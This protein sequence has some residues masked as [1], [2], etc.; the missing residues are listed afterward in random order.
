MTSIVCWFNKE[1]SESIWIVGDSRISK[2]SGKENTVLIDSGAKLF[3]IPVICRKPSETGFFDNLFYVNTLGMAYAGSSLVGLN[4]QAALSTILTNLCSVGAIPSLSEIANY[5][6]NLVQD[7]IR[8][9][10]T[11]ACDRAICEISLCGFCHVERQF[12]IAHLKPNVCVTSIDVDAELFASNQ[13]DDGFFLLL[14]DKKDY[15]KDKI[16]SLREKQKEKDIRWWRSPK[17]AIGELIDK[18]DFNTIGGHLQLGIVNQAGYSPYSVC[19]P[20][21][22]E[23]PKSY[24]SYLGFDVSGNFSQVGS[25]FVGINGMV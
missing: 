7:Y 9:L 12:K 2:N 6:A 23:E 20:I 10:G 15:V 17:F 4:V 8:S 5:S 16:V 24:L 21:E 22:G 14:G 18:G 25:C 19:R 11:I 3:G 13:V 1:A